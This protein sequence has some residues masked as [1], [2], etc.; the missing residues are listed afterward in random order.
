MLIGRCNI[1]NSVNNRYYPLW[2]FTKGFK[3]CLLL[4]LW[5]SLMVFKTCMLRRSFHAL[6]KN[7]SFSFPTDVGSHNSPPSG[8]ASSLAL[9]PFS[10]RCETPNS[11]PSGPSSLLGHHLG[12]NPHPPLTHNPPP[13]GPSVLA[14]TRS[15]LQSM[16]DPPIHSPLGLSSLPAHRLVSIP[17]RA[18]PPH[19]LLVTTKN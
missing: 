7:V 1:P 8:P 4:T 3:T 16:W 12:F 13:S 9:V 15:L 2:P 5:A 18:Q 6:I 17:F 14:S 19:W 10:N 11:P